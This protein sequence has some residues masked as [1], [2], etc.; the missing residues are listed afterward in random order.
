MPFIQFGNK[1]YNTNYIPKVT[2]IDQLPKKPEKYIL[3]SILN[4]SKKNRQ[5][6]FIRDPYV[7]NETVII[8]KPHKKGI[9]NMIKDGMLD[10]NYDIYILNSNYESEMMSYE[11]IL[12]GR[13]YCV[14]CHHKIRRNYSYGTSEVTELYWEFNTYNQAIEFI[15]KNFK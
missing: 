11:N 5:K 3:K 14:R 4:S 9:K 2:I 8:E 12:Y 15:Q 13:R 10:K 6:E 7:R 1:F